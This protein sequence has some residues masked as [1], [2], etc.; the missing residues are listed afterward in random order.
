MWGLNVCRIIIRKHEE[1]YW[2]PFPRE[3]GAFGFS[4]MANA[5]HILGLEDLRVAPAA[6]ARAVRWSRR[7][8]AT[9]T[10]ARR[11]D[12]SARY[13]FDL[14][15]GLTS[16]VTADLTYKTDFAQVEAD[17]E[18]V[19]TTRF[20][21]FFPEKRQFFTESAGIFDFGRAAGVNTQGVD[22]GGQRPPACWPSSTAVAIG[23]DEGRE[24]PISAAARS[25]GRTGSYTFG[26]MN[27]ETDRAARTARRRV[28]TWFSR[29]RTTP[30]S[31]SSA[32][33]CP[34]PSSAPSC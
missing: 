23:L 34:S 12:A 1:T 5:G 10:P 28:P 25:P 24:V 16:D 32:T 29:G 11:R 30:S 4:R 9:S 14:R 21:L 2:V 19:N 13:G 8:P 33:S 17:Q 15:L 22:S 27:I 31:G 7:S 18:V 6:R 20:S 3:W 26:L